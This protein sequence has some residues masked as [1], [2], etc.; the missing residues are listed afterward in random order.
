M[1]DVAP[2]HSSGC[3]FVIDTMCLLHHTSV[4][5]LTHVRI[6]VCVISIFQGTH[7]SLKDNHKAKATVAAIING[8]GSLGE[9]NWSFYLCRGI[10]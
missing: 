1:G 5:G 4:R 10:K 2:M 9:L 6:Y 3:S 8:T 7:K